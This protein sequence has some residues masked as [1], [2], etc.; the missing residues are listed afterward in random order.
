MI[1]YYERVKRDI[2]PRGKMSRKD[3][4]NL[5]P[6]KI[7]VKIQFGCLQEKLE[8]SSN[9]LFEWALEL[10]DD[11]KDIALYTSYSDIEEMR[12]LN[13]VLREVQDLVTRIEEIQNEYP[14]IV[15]EPCGIC[16][17]T[18]CEGYPFNTFKTVEVCPECEGRGAHRINLQ[19][20]E[21]KQI[22]IRFKRSS[23][24]LEITDDD[25][26]RFL[27]LVKVDRSSEVVI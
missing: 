11:L 13:K 24:D 15:E 26:N 6:Y 1:D 8:T 16:G 17:G 23:K 25:V 10:T 2:D 20:S 21:L 9:G 19:E 12:Y 3:I 22:K 14:T 5:L 18:G 7:K 27:E 4:L